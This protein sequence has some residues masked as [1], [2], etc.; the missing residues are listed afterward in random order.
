MCTFSFLLRYKYFTDGSTDTW[1]RV[2]WIWIR[3]VTTE[4]KECSRHRCAG[5]Y[6]RQSWRLASWKNSVSYD[7]VSAWNNYLRPLW[8]AAGQCPLFLSSSTS[9]FPPRGCKSWRRRCWRL[10]ERTHGG[11]WGFVQKVR[12]VLT[13]HG[14][15]TLGWYPLM[16]QRTRSRPTR[17][18]LW[19]TTLLSGLN[20][21]EE[22]G[23]RGLPQ[24]ESLSKL[25]AEGPLSHF[26]KPCLNPCSLTNKVEKNFC[27]SA[28]LLQWQPW[29]VFHVAY[30]QLKMSNKRH[31]EKNDWIITA[32]DPTFASENQRRKTWRGPELSVHPLSLL[33][34]LLG[35]H[36]VNPVPSITPFQ[37]RADKAGTR[38]PGQ[39]GGSS[40]ALPASW[41]PA[42]L[43]TGL[44][45]LVWPLGVGRDLRAP[46]QQQQ[47]PAHCP[48]PP[49]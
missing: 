5:M 46:A 2:W 27:V 7:S 13:D 16:T 12:S 21:Y 29:R 43:Q 36:G 26:T 40:H 28:E 48:Q 39:G 41:S 47:L 4:G 44:R 17:S 10:A 37:R 33:S 3:R 20:W 8:T 31:I 18:P 34:Q 9:S 25:K 15:W 30:A 42:Q 1:W 19:I 14:D 23:N 24:Q 6:R 32:T 45:Q 22:E 35:K 49:H 11:S 38:P